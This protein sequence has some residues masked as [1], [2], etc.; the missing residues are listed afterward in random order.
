RSARAVADPD[1]R[2]TAP[3]VAASPH[4]AWTLANPPPSVAGMR[5]RIALSAVALAGSPAP[6]PETAPPAAGGHYGVAL[7]DVEAHALQVEMACAGDGPHALSTYRSLTDAHVTDL[8]ALA[9]SALEK[10][11]GVWR[12]KGAGGVARG[13]YRFDVDEMAGATNSPSIG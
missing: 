1:L 11:E 2:L 5:V 6:A 9:G 3:P 4:R 7:A 13:A 8:R 12:L 10:M